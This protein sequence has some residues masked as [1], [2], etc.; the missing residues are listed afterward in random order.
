MRP[1]GNHIFASSL[2]QYSSLEN[3]VRPL[4]STK[5]MHYLLFYENNENLEKP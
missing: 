4:F 5:E 3:F 2:I 1:G